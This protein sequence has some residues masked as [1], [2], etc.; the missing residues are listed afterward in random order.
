MKSTLAEILDRPDDYLLASSSNGYDAAKE[1]EEEEEKV[2]QR[3]NANSLSKDGR[4]GFCVECEDQPS[5]LFCQQCIDDFCEVCFQSIHR[6]GRRR[7][8]TAKRLVESRQAPAP[9][10]QRTQMMDSSMMQVEPEQTVSI[11]DLMAAAQL[12][13]SSSVREDSVLERAKWIPVRLNLKERKL[14]RLLEAALTVN[15]YTDR[16]DVLSYRTNKPQRIVSQIKEMCSILCGLVVATD[17]EVGQELIQEKD[18]KFNANF[19]CRAFEIGRRHKVMNPEKMRSIYGKLVYLLMDAASQEIKDMLEFSLAMPLETVYRSLE[20]VQKLGLLSD[21]LIEIATQEIIPDGKSRHAIQKE[22]K[23]KERAIE[24]LASR[25]ADTTFSQEQIR[26]CLYSIGDNNSFLRSNRDPCDRMI[27]LL[28]R[29]FSPSAME[30]GFS[31][32]IGSGQG[33]A[34]LTHNHEKQYA[35]VLQS[36]TLWREMNHNMFK[37]W[38]LSEQDMLDERNPYRLRDT[39]QGLNRI[40]GCP[41]VSRAVHGILHKTMQSVGSWVGSSVVHLGDTNVPNALMF[42]K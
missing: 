3:L 23:Q 20:R 11:E 30:P 19:F 27:Q 6:K 29:Y 32:G 18:F 42:S 4:Q 5:S 17:Y 10:E 34:R 38:C 16:V 35:Y 25:F 37:L 15:E 28:Q 39:G 31:L 2:Q 22:I 14:L 7:E 21:P 36:L 33:G 40:Q 13:H 41:Q 8:H 26:Q 24:V 1:E 12:K 9:R